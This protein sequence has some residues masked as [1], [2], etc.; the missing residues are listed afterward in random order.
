ME[1][2]SYWP[3]LIAWACFKRLRFMNSNLF[4]TKFAQCQSE[5][6][7]KND[8]FYERHAIPIWNM[9][10]NQWQ[11]LERHTT[12]AKELVLL[13]S[14]I[15]WACFKRIRSMNL[16]VVIIASIFCLHGLFSLS[17][18]KKKIRWFDFSLNYSFLVVTNFKQILIILPSSGGL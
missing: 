17:S 2:W 15:A 10:Q 16:N 6:C 5:T 7:F 14:L 8:T 1:Q 13:V 18:F 3:R 12:R 4:M 11:F 9:L